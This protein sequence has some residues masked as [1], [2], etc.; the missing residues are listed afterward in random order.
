M[1]FLVFLLAVVAGIWLW[2]SGRGQ[3]LS[4]RSTPSPQ[5]PASPGAQTMIACQL[6]QLHVP[7]QDAVAGERGMYCCTAHRHQAEP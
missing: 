4:E 5:R 6:C 3:R 7:Q 1:K 2:R